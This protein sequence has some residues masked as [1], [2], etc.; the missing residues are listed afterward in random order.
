M[1]NPEDSAL[2]P[3][4]YVT[5]IQNSRHTIWITQ[6]D[7][8]GNDWKYNDLMKVDGRQEGDQGCMCHMAWAA[9]RRE[10]QNQEAQSA[11]I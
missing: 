8:D 9:E 6:T 7:D 4:S 10:R 2:P 11:S 1:H 5:K 3:S